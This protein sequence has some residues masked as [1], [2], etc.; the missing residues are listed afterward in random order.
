MSV[1][2]RVKVPNVE[3]RRLK[4]TKDMCAEESNPRARLSPLTSN[5]ALSTRQRTVLSLAPNLR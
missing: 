1:T 2:V 5:R 4:M 3:R